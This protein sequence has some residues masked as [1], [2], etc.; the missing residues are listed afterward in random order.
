ML[1]RLACV[2]HV[3]LDDNDDDVDDDDGGC[4]DDDEDREETQPGRQNS[5]PV[6]T[7]YV[8]TGCTNCQ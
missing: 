3:R 1:C 5:S 2:Q 8:L 6:R 7:R 4:D